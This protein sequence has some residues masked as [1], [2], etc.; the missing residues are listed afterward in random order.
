MLYNENEFNKITNNL[1]THYGFV[2]VSII[3]SF[4]LIGIFDLIRYIGI[5]TIRLI[6]MVRMKLFVWKIR[7][8]YKIK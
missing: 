7:R 5:T 1:L 8:K 4:G 6:F 2:L 3:V